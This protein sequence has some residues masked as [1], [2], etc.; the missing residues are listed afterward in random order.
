MVGRVGLG[1]DVGGVFGEVVGVVVGY[2]EWRMRRILERSSC[3][4]GFSGLTYTHNHNSFSLYALPPLCIK[5][6]LMR[7]C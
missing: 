6:S 3:S 2:W 1:G 5:Q 4:L 7:A